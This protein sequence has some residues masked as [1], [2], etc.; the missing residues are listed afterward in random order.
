[1]NIDAREEQQLQRAN[2]DEDTDG[3]PETGRVVNLRQE[4]EIRLADVTNRPGEPERNRQRGGEHE[5][6]QPTD[7]RDCIKGLKA[8]VGDDRELVV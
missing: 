1:M 4:V 7:D 2:R 6:K 5:S 8:H 3:R